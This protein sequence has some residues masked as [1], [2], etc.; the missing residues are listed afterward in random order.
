M[1]KMLVYLT[2]GITVLLFA[3][4]SFTEDLNSIK[5]AVDDLKIVIGTPAFKNTIHIDVKD[6]AND[7]NITGNVRIKISGDDATKIY[8]NLGLQKADHIYTAVDGMIDLVVDP[9]VDS[10]ALIQKPL[11][12]KVTPI[13][14]GYTGVTQDVTVSYETY[15]MVNLKMVNLTV[16]NLPGVN[17][18]KQQ[19]NPT[20]SNTNTTTNTVVQNVDAKNTTVEVL[21]GTTLKNQNGQVLTGNI[22]SQIVFYSPTDPVAQSI[23]SESLS[24]QLTLEDGS[25]TEGRLISAG[26]Y[27]AELKVGN[28][29]VK[30]LSGQGLKLRTRVSP[31]LI[32]PETGSAVAEGDIIPMWSQE[33]G[34]GQ[35]IL[36][37]KTI[38]KKDADGLYLED[39]VNHLSSWNWDWKTSNHC[40]TGLKINWTLNGANN[41]TISI[42][43]QFTDP[44]YVNAYDKSKTEYIKTGSYTQ[45][46]NTP[47]KAS[48]K[49]VF[50]DANPVPGITLSFSPASINFTDLCSMAPQQ[51]TVTAQNNNVYKVHLD[52]TAKSKDPKEQLIV[53]PNAYIYY[54]Q[55]NTNYVFAQM[56]NGKVDLSMEIGKTYDMKATISEDTGTGT[57]L[58]KDIGNNKLQVEFIPMSIGGGAAGDKI[59]LDPITKPAIG[60]DI[61]IN[62]T[63]YLSSDILDDI[64]KVNRKYK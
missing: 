32:N 5:T 46:N 30:T 23:I 58:I 45:L 35:W 28:E 33:T 22:N 48:G 3:R 17:I 10:L 21:S 57:I 34:S 44:K 60:G 47:Q 55:A 15:K 50:A 25:T 38:V 8:D 24:G 6:A 4:C 16:N 2:L 51:V 1:K 43:T 20:Y 39:V 56:K 7:A 42:K 29:T 62:Y 53:K 37:K 27:N 19:L 41:A 61:Y 64:Q 26:M 54:K 40:S 11:K 18:S 12:I 9:H 63:A 52:I 36:E 14:D 13:A 31:E 59:V 49:L